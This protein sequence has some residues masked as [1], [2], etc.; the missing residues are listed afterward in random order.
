MTF[1]TGIDSVFRDSDQIN[2]GFLAF[3]DRVL[4]YSPPRAH[5]RRAWSVLEEG[6]EMK[7]TSRKTL[8][9]P[10]VPHLTTTLKRMSVIFIVSDFMADD[11][12]SR[13][14]SWRSWARSTT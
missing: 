8:M 2:I 14:G 10:V 4:M 13:A 11:D 3:A 5:A 1:I 7:A 6:W 9:L 12:H